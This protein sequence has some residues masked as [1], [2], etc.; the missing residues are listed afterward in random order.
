M[1]RQ[2]PLKVVWICNSSNEK[3]CRAARLPV[4]VQA[5]WI[6]MWISEF[7]RRREVELHIISPNRFIPWIRNFTIDGVHYHYFNHRVPIIKKPWLWNLDARSSYILNRLIIRHFVNMIK[8]DLI[9]IIGAENALYSSVYFDLRR[10]YPILIGIQG[11]IFMANVNMTNPTRKRIKIEGAILSTAKYF[12]VNSDYAGSIV[13]GFNDHASIYKYPTPFKPEDYPLYPDTKKVWDCVFFGRIE[14]NKGIFDAIKALAMV[15]NQMERANLLII[16]DISASVKHE[17]LR[18]IN[19][20]ELV[21]AITFAGRTATRDE[22][23]DYVRQA[24]ISVLPSLNDISPGT[25]T[26]SLLLGNPVVSYSVGAID[27]LF[28]HTD[29]RINTVE[30]GNVQALAEEMLRIL[31]DYD[32]AKAVA[33]EARES[34]LEERQNVNI[35]DLFIG[36]YRQIL[37]ESS[38]A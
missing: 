15:R 7:E 23:F 2:K 11:F 26:E 27:E 20:L 1:D 38:R 14:Y 25:I 22:L 13:R 30:R 10:R 36:F 4:F 16:G 17:I 29:R 21:S 37:Q 6:S 3:I 24:R 31:N 33:L 12:N 28:N 19:E 9:H 35:A 5:P 18:L 8:P 32:T 34:F